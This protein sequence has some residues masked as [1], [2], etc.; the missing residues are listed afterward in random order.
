MPNEE[1]NV[2][3][4]IKVYITDVKKTTKGPQISLSVLIP[5]SLKDYFELEVPEIMQGDVI[6]KNIAREAE[7]HELKLQY[8]RLMK[9]STSVGFQ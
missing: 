2:N 3:D 6:I 9:E 8:M 4:R 1:Y 7:F 5:I